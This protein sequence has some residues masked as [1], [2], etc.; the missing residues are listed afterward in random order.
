[1][2]DQYWDTDWDDDRE[3]DAARVAR[4]ARAQD[5]ILQILMRFTAVTPAMRVA[6]DTQGIIDAAARMKRELD[7]VLDAPHIKAPMM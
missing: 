1:M 6:G 3:I 5:E 4:A 2:Q 7:A